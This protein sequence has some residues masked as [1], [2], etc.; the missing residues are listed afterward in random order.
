V[1]EFPNAEF[2]SHRT[3]SLPFSAKLTR[4]DVDDVVQ[5]VSKILTYYGK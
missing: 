2:I 4:H 5:A 1:G 3:F